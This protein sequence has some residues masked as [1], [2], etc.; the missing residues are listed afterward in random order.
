MNLSAEIGK[1]TA[2]RVSE[3]I[4]I[5]QTHVFSV[6]L[7]FQVLV[8]NAPLINSNFYLFSAYRF[9]LPLSPSRFGV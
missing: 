4:S 5:E 7:Q 3:L 9:P 6:S 2:E 1:R 8:R